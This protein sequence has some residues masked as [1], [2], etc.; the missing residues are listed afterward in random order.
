MGACYSSVADRVDDPAQDPARGGM[1][2]H[3]VRNSTRRCLESSFRTRSSSVSSSKL[4]F[5][6]ALDSFANHGS[7][8]VHSTI[9]QF[10][11]FSAHRLCEE[12]LAAVGYLALRDVAEKLSLPLK[13]LAAFCEAVDQNMLPNGYHSR[14]H[15]ADVLQLMVLQTIDDG[16]SFY[17]CIELLQPALNEPRSPASSFAVVNGGSTRVDRSCFRAHII[18]DGIIIG[19]WSHCRHSRHKCI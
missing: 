10:D 11:V 8:H 14:L 4:G 16:E 9:D 1:A 15:V 3:V 2:L 6:T 5:V 7:H 18:L 19:C 12:T 17:H 13:T